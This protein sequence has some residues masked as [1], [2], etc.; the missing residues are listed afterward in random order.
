[1][2]H[3]FEDA[4]KVLGQPCR[5][6]ENYLTNLKIGRRYRFEFSKNVGQE[7]GVLNNFV[8]AQRTQ[9]K[10]DSSHADTN[11]SRTAT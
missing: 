3:S 9:S 2:S 1:M 8:K 6:L 10:P 11:H 5:T 7:I 4:A